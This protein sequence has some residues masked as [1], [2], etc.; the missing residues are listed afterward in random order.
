MKHVVENGDS[1]L[2]IQKEGPGRLYYRLALD[3]APSDFKLNSSSHGFFVSRFYEAVDNENDVK[4]NNDGSW[5]FKL[6]SK[7]KV[8]INMVTTSRRYHIALVD[9]V[10]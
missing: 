5:T 1:S 4:Q 8:K 6:G 10:K 9:K 2:V 3:Y 7:I